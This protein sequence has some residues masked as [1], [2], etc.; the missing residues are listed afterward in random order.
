MDHWYKVDKIFRALQAAEAFIDKAW[1]GE[2]LATEQEKERIDAQIEEAKELVNGFRHKITRPN[3]IGCLVE[4]PDGPGHILTLHPNA[5]I[6]VLHSISPGQEMVGRKRASAGEM[7]YTYFYHEVALVK[8][9][10]TLAKIEN[11][12]Q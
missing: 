1:T 2:T 4:T 7:H 12:E 10:H 8:N 9:P 11:L 3:L 6:V 5:I